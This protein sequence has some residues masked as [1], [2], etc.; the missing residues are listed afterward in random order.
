MSW[1]RWRRRFQ[2]VGPWALPTGLADFG[3]SIPLLSG[4]WTGTP[5]SGQ[6]RPCLSHGWQLCPYR[7]EGA[8]RHAVH[9]EGNAG[10]VVTLPPMKL[11]ALTLVR[12]P[13]LI[14]AR[15]AKFDLEAQRGD[16]RSHWSVKW[17]NGS[18]VLLLMH[19]KTMLDRMELTPCNRIRRFSTDSESS[20][21]LAA[22]IC[23]M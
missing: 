5:Q 4:T 7:H 14:G 21:R 17:F 18:S 11:M 9:I 2:G 15:W 10:A 8:A 1:W 23:R 20:V 13:E 22:M 12:T 16:S 6:R 3:T 19:C